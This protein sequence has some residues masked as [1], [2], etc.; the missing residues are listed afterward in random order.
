MP[1]FLKD[2][3][4]AGLVDMKAIIGALEAIFLKESR[5]E[6]FNQP[7][8]RFNKGEARLNVMLAGDTTN[9]RHAI[10]AYGTIGASVSHIF[11]YGAEGLLAVIEAKRLSSLRTGAAS[12][13]AA[14]RLAAPGA[15]IVGIVGAGRQADFQLAAFKSVRPIEQVRA[16]ARDRA[17]L[18]F[19]CKRASAE[20]SIPVQPAPS[21]EAAVA[22]ADIAVAA[23][24]AREP[25]LFADW[26]EPGAMV[27][28]MGANAA[29]RRELDASIVTQA[30]IVVADDPQQARI[31]AGE[32][33]DLAKGGQFDWSRLVPLNAIVASPPVFQP[34]RFT[35]FKSLGAG[36]EDLAAASLV[37]D[38]ALRRGVGARL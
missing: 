22:G 18:D 17:K 13:V 9:A 7:R 25:V 34:G 24:N 19:F 16:F 14:D 12:G 3:D 36:I 26:I 1:L 10:R 31:E 35:L 30:S 5:G 4:V 6:A 23:T 20:L 2:A 21:A 32:F 8:H 28:G 37:Y 11:L 29:H 33:I 15:R 27:I 38:E